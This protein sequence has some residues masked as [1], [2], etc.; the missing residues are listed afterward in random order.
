MKVYFTSDTHYHHTNIIKYCERP[1]TD[2]PSMH[3]G[4]VAAWNSTVADDDVVFHLG[5]Y[6]L[7][8]SSQLH[9]LRDMTLGLK[10]SKFLV[11]GNH[12]KLSDDFLL[13]SGFKSTY[14]S[15]NIGGVLL[16]HH[17]LHEA[18][19]RDLCILKLGPFD[20]VVHGHIHHRDVPNF[21]AHYNVAVDRNEFK[22]VPLDVAV[23]PHLHESFLQ[24]LKRIVV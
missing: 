10:G 22:P 8:K 20:H 24:D 6:A 9:E 23:P 7:P 13:S 15:I 19:T 11:R 4:L 2:I 12:D 21:D 5:D 1:F 17:P 14:G 18:I 3:E 16:T